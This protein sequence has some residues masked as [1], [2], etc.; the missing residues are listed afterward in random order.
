M[1][2]DPAKPAI[3][4]PPDT[5]I[6]TPRAMR[7][8]TPMWLCFLALGTITQLGFKIASMPLEGLE[9][10]LDWLRVA[11]TTPAFAIAV[12]SYLA[13]FALWIVILQRTP[14]SRGFLLT[15]LVYVTVTLGSAVWLGESVNAAQT[16]GIALVIAGVALLGVTGRRA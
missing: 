15:A 8:D 12:G 10:G 11:S 2:L 16:A 9:F 13:T 3:S 4:L 6:R 1:T 5:A 7:T 14:L